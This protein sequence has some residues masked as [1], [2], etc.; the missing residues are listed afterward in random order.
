MIQTTIRISALAAI[1]GTVALAEDTSDKIDVLYVT[2]EP[3]KH[4]KYTPQREIFEKLA[5]ESGWNL[6]VMSGNHDEV[7]EKLATQP[8]FGKGADVIVYNFCMAHSEK[9]NA[10]YNIINQTK[11]KG[12]PAL[13]VHCSLHSFWATYKKGKGK[14]WVHPEGANAKVKAKGKL[15]AQWKE[16]HP[17]AEFPA[18]T[19]MTGIASTK[20]AK[21]NPIEAKALDASHPVFIGVENY[22]THAQAELYYN[23]ITAEESP[24]S[25][26][27]MTGSQGEVDAAILW[28]HPLGKSKSLSF[29]LG[30]GI[31]EWEQEPFQKILV[32]SVNYLA[33]GK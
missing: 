3:G 2:H 17:D 23:F 22:T 26:V 19:N 20:H 12:I 1:I 14:I 25:K 29:T 32:N 18:W 24:T 33:S 10:P 30:H 11:E 8:D 9:L 13:L 16:K 4:H 28:E 27:L 5:K 7:E 6:T 31:K 15:I 21:R